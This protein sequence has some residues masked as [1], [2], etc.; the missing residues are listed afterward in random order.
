VEP[1]NVSPDETLLLKAVIKAKDDKFLLNL[2]LRACAQLSF[3]ISREHP[4]FE[5]F[6]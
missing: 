1:L 2:L 4:D 3:D 5:A 6:V